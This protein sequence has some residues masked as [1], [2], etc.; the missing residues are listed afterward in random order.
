ME[1]SCFEDCAIIFDRGEP[2]K[3][4]TILVF[5]KLQLAD[6]VFV[7]FSHHHSRGFFL[8]KPSSR[9]NLAN[10]HYNQSWWLL[11]SGGREPVNLF[12]LL[13]QRLKMQFGWMLLLYFDTI[14]DSF[15]ALNGAPQLRY[16]PELQVDKVFSYCFFGGFTWTIL[17]DRS[18]TRKKPM[19]ALPICVSGMW[20]FV[21][22]H[23]DIWPIVW[24]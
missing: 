4:W 1:L 16:Q 21:G 19:S 10:S 11:I 6:H 13:N 17:P 24:C 5:L 9:M 22:F 18:E 23:D 14:E 15:P 2:S 8:S 12:F 20:S 3:N 7:R